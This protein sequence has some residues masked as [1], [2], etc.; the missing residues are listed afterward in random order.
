[1]Q[2]SV[3][4]ILKKFKEDQERILNEG[5]MT[6]SV[7]QRQFDSEELFGQPDTTEEEDESAK[8]AL[9]ES[10]SSQNRP[11][12]LNEDLYDDLDQ[13]PTSQKNF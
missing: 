2:E 10:S 6:G 8:D 1:M 13:E 9:R 11:P 12:K 7:S 3:S 5:L 4:D